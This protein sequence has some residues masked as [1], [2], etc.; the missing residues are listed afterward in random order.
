MKCTWNGPDGNLEYTDLPSIMQYC[1]NAPSY[2]VICPSLNADCPCSEVVDGKGTGLNSGID[3]TKTPIMNSLSLTLP[4]L[5]PSLTPTT[6]PH[7][8]GTDSESN[9][10]VEEV[11]IAYS[12]QFVTV[13]WFY[14][15]RTTNKARLYL[16][17]IDSNTITPLRTVRIPSETTPDLEIMATTGSVRVYL[18]ADQGLVRILFTLD[19]LIEQEVINVAPTPAPFYHGEI[20]IGEQSS[21]TQNVGQNGQNGQ[22]SV[23]TSFSPQAINLID[24][25]PFEIALTDDSNLNTI[26]LSTSF[27]YL[28]NRCNNTPCQN[29]VSCETWSNT[30]QV[31]HC[32]SLGC[33][34][35]YIPH[36][37][38]NTP[39]FWVSEEPVEEPVEG[40]FATQNLGHEGQNSG[41]MSQNRPQNGQN[42]QN[43]RIARFRPQQTPTSTP[44]TFETSLQS[45]TIDYESQELDTCTCIEPYSGRFCTGSAF[46]DDSRCQND[47][48]I[49]FTNNLCSPQSA[50]ACRNHWVG[51]VCEMCSLEGS[52]SIDPMGKC[53]DNSSPD[54]KCGKCECHF[55]TSRPFFP[56]LETPKTYTKSTPITETTP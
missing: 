36:D 6:Y 41:K 35:M 27:F 39:S 8:T 49:P 45:C 26:V 38:M 20:G 32:Y 17:N 9:P 48:Y 16:H 54:G 55:G 7:L 53:G 12:E 42:G 19:G 23:H 3:C 33:R 40:Q 25:T 43:G 24:P 37:V 11:G 22:N 5:S 2:K 46:C 47:G 28:Q 34:N 10:I 18:P 1:P 52:G 14:D 44:L 15:G 56:D 51:E 30:C 50:C 31:D 21:Q 13:R 29:K 4:P